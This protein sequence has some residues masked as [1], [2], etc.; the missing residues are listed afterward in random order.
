MVALLKSGQSTKS[1]FY[2]LDAQKAAF[3]DF[4]QSANK[5]Q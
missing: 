3:G 2:E 1:A 4:N 5:R